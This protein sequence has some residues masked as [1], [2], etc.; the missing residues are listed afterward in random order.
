MGG[1]AIHPANV[2]FYHARSDATRSGRENFMRILQTAPKDFTRAIPARLVSSASQW[3]V[4][5]TVRESMRTSGY[6][7]VAAGV[8]GSLA[9]VAVCT[10]FYQTYAKQ[11][12][13]G[14][15]FQSAATSVLT[16]MKN[17]P[18]ITALFALAAA[19]EM[20]IGDAAQQV[21]ERGLR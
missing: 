8:T 13:S 14:G 9:G 19:G 15:S 7:D 16:C 18:G 11:I 12:Q 4:F 5:F 20:F 10:P 2:A 3:S 6:S 1:L 17:K 21:L